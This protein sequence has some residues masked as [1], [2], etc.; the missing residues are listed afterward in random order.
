MAM[1]YSLKV[2]LA[3]LLLVGSAGLLSA[4]ARHII[5]FI[6][7]GMQM[8]AEV[9]TSRYLFG[10]DTALSFH[11]LPRQSNVTTWDV[12]T[13]NVWATE[14]AQPFYD[15]TTIVPMI[16][17]DPL[18]GGLLPFPLQTSGQ[19]EPY[20]LRKAADSASTATALATG[21]KTDT[22][23]ISWR[24]GDPD[25]GELET[26]GELLRR[27]R[28]FKFG[29]VSTVQI[30]HATPSAHASHSI[31]RV[32][33]HELANTMLTRVEPDVVIGGG[34][35]GYYR[36]GNDQYVPQA[37]YDAFVAGEREDE[38][39]FAERK[40][41]A[42][43]ASALT[44][45]AARAVRQ[46]KKLFALFGGPDGSFETP[47]PQDAPG[48]PE[49]VRATTENPLLWQTVAPT[50]DVLSDDSPGFVVMFEQGDI[51]W[52]AHDND[53]SGIVGTTWDLHMAV[54]AAVDYVD[55]AGDDIDWSNT[56]LIVTSDHANSYLRLVGELAAGDLPAQVQEQ[57]RYSYPDG[58]VTFGSGNH[59]NEMVRLYARGAGVEYLDK[60]EGEWYPCTKIIDD[61]Q[62]FEMMVEA[63]G[64]DRKSPLTVLPSQAVCETASAGR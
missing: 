34:H 62:V 16:G 59:T 39:V 56:L 5:L 35:P 26:I 18:R 37:L 1:S 33:Y 38:Y 64:L 60:H 51:D 2:S 15:P 42:D 47:V 28:G 23:N 43:G 12:D 36:G 22:G 54:Q 48:K 29:V 31:N 49:V 52:G 55:R 19:D 27:T 46:D 41:G 9:A 30:S 25:D 3:L 14:A 17:Y 21:N 8:E 7:D 24:L 4:E 6:G 57:R 45:A 20:L 13:Y 58:E 44:A 61:T 50:L 53:Y 40:E 10:E 32:N 63:A 11:R